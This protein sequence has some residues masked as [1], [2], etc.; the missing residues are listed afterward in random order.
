MVQR[1]KASVLDLIL[2]TFSVSNSNECFK[3]C[4]LF[5]P[6]GR[7]TWLIQ[8][9]SDS[10]PSLCLV[11]ISVMCNKAITQSYFKLVLFSS[12]CLLIKKF[13]NIF[14]FSTTATIPGQTS[15]DLG[16]LPRQGLLQ[17]STCS[18]AVWLSPATHGI[19]LENIDL[20]RLPQITKRQTTYK[21]H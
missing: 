18:P 8:R 16:S 11:I 4:R 12:S 7:K 2:N 1:R 10:I 3:P 5:L 20:P 15:V 9:L 13:L 14:L 19:G 6:I 17:E 21:T